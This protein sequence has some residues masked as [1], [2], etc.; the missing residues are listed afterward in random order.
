MNIEKNI[1]SF[2]LVKVSVH[3]TALIEIE[4][5][6]FTPLALQVLHS[7]SQL[8]NDPDTLEH[9]NQYLPGS[10]AAAARES[11]VKSRFSIN[12]GGKPSQVFLWLNLQL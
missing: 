2:L 9:L 3:V 10:P 1:F 4:N 8:D 7:S 5:T 11:G 12:A 6:L